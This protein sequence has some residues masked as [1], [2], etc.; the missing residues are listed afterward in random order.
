MNWAV[1]IPD[2][3]R[4]RRIPEAF[5]RDGFREFDPIPLE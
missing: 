3:P 2:D 4:L 1:E 5:N